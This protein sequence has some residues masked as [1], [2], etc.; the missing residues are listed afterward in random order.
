VAHRSM[1]LV[2]AFIILGALPPAARAAVGGG[3]SGPSLIS[4]AVDGSEADGASFTPAISADGRYV[5]FT[6]A[7][8]TLVSGDSNGVE[9][10]FVFDRVTRSTERES[11]SSAGEQGDGDSYGPAISADG[12]YV[13]FTSAASNLTAG[14]ANSNLDIFVRD[15]LSRVTVLASVGPH[16]TMADGPSVAPSISGDGRLVAFESDA[17]TLV[18]GDTNGTGDVFVNDVVTGMTRRLSVGGN[19]QQTESPSFGAAISADGRAVAF[20]SFSSRLVPGDTNGALDVFVA[21]V[22]TGNLDRVSLSTDGGQADNR[23]YSPSISA[24][25]RIV[26]FSSFADNLVPDDTNGLLDVFI[27]RRD[28]KTTTRL[29]V[30][31]DGSGADGL[32]FAPVV[33][34]DG[35]L[36]VFSSEAGNLVADDSNG[37][38]DVFLAS[39][40]TGALSRLSRPRSGGKGQGDGPSLGPVVDASGMMVA[41]ASFATNLVPGDTNGQSDVFVTQSP[42]RPASKPAAGG[43]K[44]RR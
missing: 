16:G 10:V 20:E 3:K 25:G 14:D 22:A 12:R 36:V 19:G 32:S 34:A 43:H 24:D 33:S 13:A 17:A 4:L 2:V 18:P 35:A 9:D 39:T 11:L 1:R 40:T 21:D 15:R 38:R 44:S 26:A 41:F 23:S 7:A 30:A 29:S 42:Q 27:R 6:S 31:P 8:S 5:A 28:Q 37:T